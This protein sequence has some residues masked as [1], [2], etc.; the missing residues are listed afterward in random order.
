MVSKGQDNF[1]PYS[2]LFSKNNAQSGYL[3]NSTLKQHDKP[4]DLSTEVKDAY[5]TFFRKS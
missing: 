4:L 1:V 3:V 2:F 5:M